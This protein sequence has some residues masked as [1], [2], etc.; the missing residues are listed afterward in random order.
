MAKGGRESTSRDSDEASPVR[1]EAGAQVSDR[2]RL[3]RPL[4][5]GGMGSVWVARH[6]TLD[7][8]VAVKFIAPSLGA[9]DPD[10]L[11]R[12]KREAQL[13][14]K[15]AGPHVVRTLD[16]GVTRDGVPYIAMELLKGE[17]LAERIERAGPIAPAELVRI[18]D[19]VAEGLAE[20]HA[21]GIVHRDI[22]PQNLFV[23]RSPSGKEV[24][25]VLDFG[26]ARSESK[27]D[28]VT[29]S[30]GVL[31]TALYMSPEQ[32]ME[33]GS[34]DKSADL[35]ALA[36][37]AYEALTRRHAFGRD[38][39]GAT[40]MAV[41]R[42]DFAPVSSHGPFPASV[43][44]FFV[45]AFSLDK[46]KRFATAPELSRALAAAL[47]GVAPIPVSEPAQGARDLTALANEP[48]GEF[49]ARQP[50]EL[51]HSETQAL[52]AIEPVTQPPS[53]DAETAK[54]ELHESPP[55]GAR[56]A[57]ETPRRRRT[58][59]WAAMGVG[60]AA[61]VGGLA[62]R[63]RRTEPAPPPPMP[64]VQLCT[65]FTIA[66][67][68]ARCLVPVPESAIPRRATTF[69]LT[70]SAHG[71]DT[72]EA[73]N[74]AGLATK[75]GIVRVELRRAGD[76]TISDVVALN[77]D[78]VEVWHEVWREGGELVDYV[79]PDGKSPRHR[80]DS[81]ATRVR[82][83]FDDRGLVT[84]ERFFGV[85][86]HPRQND[87]VF[88]RLLEWSP[89]GFKLRETY[90]GADGAP[91]ADKRGVAVVEH[92]R[93][94]RGLKV[95]ESY[96]DV[97][98][99]PL[100]YY[101]VA[102]ERSTYDDA[103]ELTETAFLDAERR[104]TSSLRYG[105]HGV[106]IARDAARRT[107][108]VTLFDAAGRPRPGGQDGSPAIFDE[109]YDERWR[110]IEKT[111]RDPSGNALITVEYG[112]AG[113]RYGF[114]DVGHVISTEGLDTSGKPMRTMFG[115]TRRVDDYDVRGNFIAQHHLDENGRPMMSRFEPATVEYGYDDRGLQTTARLLGADGK[116]TSIVGGFA[117]LRRRF[118][119]LRNLIEEACFGVDGKPAVDEAGISV[120][121]TTFDDD[122][123]AAEES[124]WDG[125]G[126]LVWAAG[127][128]KRQRKYDELGFVIEEAYFDTNDAPA[129]NDA[130]CAI[131]RMA[132]DRS[133]DLTA[134]TCFDGKGTGIDFTAG[135]RKRH[136]RRDAHRRLTE[137]L[138]VD[139]SDAA[140][141]GDEGWATTR[142]A[143]DERGLETTE[144]FF[145]AAGAPVVA[146]AGYASKTSKRDTRGNVI[147]VATLDAKGQPLAT[148][149]GYAFKRTTYDELDRVVEEGLFDVA[150]AP[151]VGS[152]GWSVRK[153]RYDE[154]GNP[155]EETFLDASRAPVLP[156][157]PAYARKRDKFDAFRHV[158]ETAYFDVGGVPTKGP[159]GVEMI[160]Y[161][162]DSWGHAT[163]TRYL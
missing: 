58:L 121:R 15:L 154:L 25:K 132:R 110:L 92:V 79:E 40:V 51:A 88:G 65:N 34:P 127:F 123:N 148:K 60:T 33:P 31:G 96:R 82:R 61:I 105:T 44:A 87:G 53:R 100:L 137:V 133:G 43:D 89:A 45:R 36:V 135:Y 140:K 67:D 39:V 161:V 2:L 14:A 49:L 85:T 118:N 30:G 120:Y 71:F 144:S 20:A 129:S 3:V 153:L 162:R 75:G 109:L 52:T 78:G 107:R 160:R 27:E 95:E 104:P 1:L 83:T 62:L 81:F 99:K 149:A 131:V 80:D 50:T 12:F 103:L 41:A 46:A 70:R 159:E 68:G 106:R 38:T 11:L 102:I 163:E 57:P 13:A 136:E 86:D 5:Q 117:L 19:D 8:D 147:E 157:T 146:A 112:T 56:A 22:K 143:Y 26:I 93:D 130:G 32:L 54:T 119:P 63:T 10:V 4:G 35:W 23:T 7:I 9:I 59:G 74:S 55:L 76:G 124:H 90:L 113:F 64:E 114:D 94:E 18:V 6:A 73:L 158:V 155:T 134:E 138:L 111:D 139:A 42:A 77:R 116:P 150:G 101:G 108:R 145:D 24:V 122:D 152:D 17:S 21:L 37:V 125:S 66:K 84:K 28:A 91:M 98:G 47:E 126:A 48:T 128:A 72:V 69:R 156:K 115:W 16:H 151:T 29:A 97:D 142:Y 141:V